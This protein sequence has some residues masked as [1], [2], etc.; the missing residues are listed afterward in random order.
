LS[1]KVSSICYLQTSYNDN[2]RLEHKIRLWTLRMGRRIEEGEGNDGVLCYHQVTY[3]L[4]LE[5]FSR[6]Y[7]TFQQNPCFGWQN[8][9][10]IPNF[11]MNPC[12]GWQNWMCYLINKDVTFAFVSTNITCVNTKVLNDFVGCLLLFFYLKKWFSC[13]W[14]GLG[15]KI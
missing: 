12:F 10:G 9:K 13:H 14:F 2:S 6:V 3:M 1:I 15:F 7:Q 11:S 4:I 5:C 8:W